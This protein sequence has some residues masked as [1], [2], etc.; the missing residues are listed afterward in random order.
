MV[1]KPWADEAS[2]QRRLGGLGIS[3]QP[4]SFCLGS[5]LHL[6]YP[7]CVPLTMGSLFSGIGGLELGLEWAGLGP[8]LWQVEC[9]PKARTVLEAQWPQAIRFDDVRS[10]GMAT[11]PSVD[12]ICG[13]FPCQDVSSAG[14]RAGLQGAQSGLWSE[15]DR[16]VGAVRPRWVVVENVASGAKLWVDTVLG[17]LEQRGYACLPIPLSASDVGAPHR[18]ARIFVVAHDQG[19][20]RRQGRSRGL[21]SGAPQQAKQAHRPA[22]NALSQGCKRPRSHAHQG[23]VRP[24][25]SDGW[26]PECGLV[27]LVHGVSTRMVGGAR[28]EQIRLL[29]NSVVPQC[30]EVV[31]WVIR[32][33]S[34]TC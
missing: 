8:V 9:N 10:V 29:G 32:E 15:F 12:L 22:S 19:N 3:P 31:G 34:G 4:A 18:R 26:Q 27:P 30:A 7:G 6:N 20:G 14:S 1:S 21:D 24:T 5:K 33:L 16:I 13:G 11:L 2:V 28:R 23:R 17:D 25:S